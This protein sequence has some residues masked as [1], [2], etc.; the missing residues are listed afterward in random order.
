MTVA[1]ETVLRDVAVAKY[2]MSLLAS[3]RHVHQSAPAN[4][5]VMTVAAVNALTTALKP[6]G[7]ATRRLASARALASQTARERIV[8]RTTAGDLA[9]IALMGRVVTKTA[10]ARPTA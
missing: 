10:S 4:A 1:V 8:D 2:A 5:V 7:P 6:G 3:A 9:V